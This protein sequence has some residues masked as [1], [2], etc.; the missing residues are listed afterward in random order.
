MNKTFSRVIVDG[1]DGTGKSTLVQSLNA[2][3]YLAQDRGNAT[4][5]TDDE[6]TVAE[7]DAYYLILLAPP[8]VCHRRLQEAGKPMDEVW[9]TMESLVHYARRYE[10][11]RPRLLHVTYLT[12]QATP[13][14]TLQNALRALAHVGIIPHLIACPILT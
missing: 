6:T 4:K 14:A 8:E 10:E 2:L 1:L 3:G 12:S 13:Q 9:H 5:M 7:A 11:I